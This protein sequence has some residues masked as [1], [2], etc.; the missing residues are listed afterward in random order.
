MESFEGVLLDN[1]EVHPVEDPNGVPNKVLFNLLL[2]Y[3]D[4]HFKTILQR[5]ETNGFDDKAVLAL[6]AQ[7][8]SITSAQQNATQRD[9]TGLKIASRESLA[10]HLCH[11]LLARDNAETVGNE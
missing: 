8:A 5:K 1:Y 10:S 3:V 4:L 6:Q 7:C 9:F 11:F 2:T